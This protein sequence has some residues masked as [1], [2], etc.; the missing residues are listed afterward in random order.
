MFV[1]VQS[2]FLIYFDHLNYAPQNCHSYFTVNIIEFRLVS[3]KSLL[4]HM[5]KLFQWIDIL[6][7]SNDLSCPISK[8][9]KSNWRSFDV[10]YTVYHFQLR[11]F[12]QIRTESGKSDA[13]NGGN[14]FQKKWFSL[15]VFRFL[16]SFLGALR[17][18]SMFVVSKIWMCS[19]RIRV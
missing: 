4:L 13:Q 2:L 3:T 19:V 9:R 11:N 5:L 1:S 16:W 12:F 14:K 7:N 8:I 18:S 15:R 17:I 6:T 10:L